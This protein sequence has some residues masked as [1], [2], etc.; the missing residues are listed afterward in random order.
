[1]KE[2]KGPTHRN[3]PSRAA[4][5]VAVL[6]L[7]FGIGSLVYRLLH[8][9][10]LE[11]SAAFFIGLPAL[12]AVVAA[13]VALYLKTD[14]AA[15]ISIKLVTIVL[16][17]AGPLLNEGFICVILAAPL[18][19]AV[20][21]L[22]ALAIDGLNKWRKR[23]SAKSAPLGLLLVLPL[24]AFSLEG[25]MPEL[26]LPR[27]GTSTALRIVDA[28]PAQVEAAL[29]AS[30]HFDRELPALLQLGF[31]TPTAA[32]GGGLN[33]GDQRTIAFGRRELVLG[34]DEHAANRVHFRTLRDDTKV[35]EWLAWQSA[36]VTWTDLGDGRTAV[37]W[38]LTYTRR[39]DPAWYFGPWEALVTTQAADYLIETAATPAS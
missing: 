4:L 37:Q 14:S 32:R 16:L 28:S 35:A 29:S 19:Y 39:L 17:L 9:A 3:L 10:R 38:T 12:M 18:F 11:Q 31:P 20:A 8:T 1:V 33:I 5:T 26:S 36:E 27:S 7:G 22:V 21:V 24:L 6:C 2:Q 34:V 15:G 23:Q 30:P 25:T 13:L